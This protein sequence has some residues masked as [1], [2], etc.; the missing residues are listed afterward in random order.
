L[1]LL[2][3]VEAPTREL[4]WLRKALVEAHLDDRLL[5]DHESPSVLVERIVSAIAP[6]TQE[7]ARRSPSPTELVL[8]RLVGGGRREE[9]FVTKTELRNKLD[10]VPPALRAVFNPLGLGGE[11][12]ASAQGSEPA[13]LVMAR[14]A[15][16][17]DAHA[18]DR[19]RPASQGPG[20]AS[21]SEEH[22]AANNGIETVPVADV[23]RRA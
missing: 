21:T 4:A 23:P 16:A 8:K 2:E 20:S 1:Q 6:L 10:R 9:I 18:S 5:R 19:P 3:K 12:G 7:I 13:T 11:N 14:R 15:S 22:A 17:S